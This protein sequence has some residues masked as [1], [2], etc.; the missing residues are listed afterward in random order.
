[1]ADGLGYWLVASDG[2][3]FAFGDAPF[4]GSTGGERAQR[5]DRGHGRRRRR[6]AATGW[7]PPTAG[8]SPSARPPSRARPARLT[9]NQ[10]MVGMVQ[11]AGR[12]RARSRP[13]V[14]GRRRRADAACAR[15]RAGSS[16]TR[17]PSR[18]DPLGA[19]AARPGSAGLLRRAAA[20]PILPLRRACF[21]TDDQA[22]AAL[23][24]P[25]GKP[26]TPACWRPW[27]RWCRWRPTWP[28]RHFPR[29]LRGSG[30]S[31]AIHPTEPHW[32]LATLGTDPDR[33]G[34]RG[35]LGPARP[36][37]WPAATRT[38]YGPT[39]SPPRSRTSP[40][41]R[42]HGFEVTGEVRLPGGPTVWPMWRD[43]RPPGLSGER[44][45]S[46]AGRCRRVQT[47][48]QRGGARRSPRRAGR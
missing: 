46:R 12:T 13:A 24:A 26:T 28:G 29:A 19:P 11:A 45:Q 40:F 14:G 15:R 27:R 44:G 30:P 41:Y 8:S 4:R 5:P 47:V 32:Y 48:G 31:E 7:W 38:G 43:P 3:V 9:L 2:G 36:R 6:R 33:A 1:M 39:S 42:R 25:P 35:W 16:A 17:W 22:G 20:W 23:W 34:P 21:T 37:S 18:P 10:P